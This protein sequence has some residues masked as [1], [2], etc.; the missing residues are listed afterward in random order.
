VKRILNDDADVHTPYGATEAMPVSSISGR[1]ILNG[2]GEKARS[3]AGTCVGE[4]LSALDVTVVPLTDRALPEWSDD[5][6]VPP[7]E[8]GEIAV[9][10]PVVTLEYWGRPDATRASKIREGDTVWHRMGDVGYRD[11]DGRLWY[12]GRKSHCVRTREGI[13]FT[14]P[15]ESIFNEHPDVH[16]TALVG[17]GPAGDAA[18]VLVV[19]PVRG[20]FP[21]SADVG[22]F[23]AELL[24]LGQANPVSRPVTRFLFHKSLPVDIRHNIKINREALAMWAAKQPR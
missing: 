23:R 13:L 8:I 21:R 11:A 18:P 4:S 9:T 20:R 17:V 1:E 16:R 7:G 19:E 5:L 10:G 15:I 3:G 24:E 22:R 6:L 12:C 2:Y 14:D